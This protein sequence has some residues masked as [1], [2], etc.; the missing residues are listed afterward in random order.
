MPRIAHLH[1]LSIA[2]FL[3]CTSAWAQTSVEN[4]RISRRCTGSTLSTDSTALCPDDVVRD[5]PGPGVVVRPPSGAA[6]TGTGT[7]SASGSTAPFGGVPTPGAPITSGG[8]TPGTTTSTGTTPG[9]PSA[10]SATTP[11]SPST[12]GGAAPGNGT[13]TITSGSRSVTFGRAR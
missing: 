5:R 7:T 8:T 12:S 6:T 3:A 9:T 1:V 13:G 4:D 2:L 10:S 11:G